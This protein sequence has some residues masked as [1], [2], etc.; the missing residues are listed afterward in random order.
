MTNTNNK[1]QIGVVGLAVMGKNLALNMESKG[2][3][4]AV[5]NRSPEKTKE[6]VEEAAG[7]NLVGCYSVEEFVNALE[8]PRKIMIMVKAG[9]PTDKTIESLLPHLDQGDIIIDGGN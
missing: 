6:L 4:V 9:E 2:F 1:Q 8:T 7:K 5:Y 3:S